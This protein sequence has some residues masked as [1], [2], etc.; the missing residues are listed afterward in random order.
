LCLPVPNGNCGTRTRYRSS[1]A[2]DRARLE[3]SIQKTLEDTNIKLAC[4]A[5]DITGQSGR[6]ILKAMLQG[7][8][9]PQQ[10]AEL[11]RGRMKEKREQLAQ[12]LQGTLGDHHRF[13]LEH[14]LRQLDFFDQQV[15]E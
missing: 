14:Q 11:A 13:L 5:S 12:A 10:L 6:A 2:A 8:Q 4:V 1:L 9:E 15:R 3:S 7:E